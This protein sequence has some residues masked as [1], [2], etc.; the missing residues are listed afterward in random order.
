MMAGCPATEPPERL[1]QGETRTVRLPPRDTTEKTAS[2]PRPRNETRSARRVT[3]PEKQ[4]S[5]PIYAGPCPAIGL[6]GLGFSSRR[7][8]DYGSDKS[9]Q[10]DHLAVTLSIGQ[11]LT[12]CTP[13]VSDRIHRIAP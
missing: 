13:A 6:A 10:P 9:F 12:A 11:D 1:S 8:P 2:H 7:K 4:I 5:F 3:A